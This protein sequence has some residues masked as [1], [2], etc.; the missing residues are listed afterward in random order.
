MK[1]FSFILGVMLFG[2]TS[3]F[4]QSNYRC[5]FSANVPIDSVQVKNMVSGKTKMLYYPDN[6]ITLQ[7]VGQTAIATVGNSAFLQ[8]TANNIVSVNV[9]TTSQLNLTLYSAN[10]T[11]VARYVNAVSAGQYSF[12]IGASAGVYVL[13]ATAGNQSFSIKLFLAKNTPIGIWEIVEAPKISLKSEDDEI[14]F[15]KDDEFEFT[16]YFKE[17]TD[18]KKSKITE[19]TEIVFTFVNDFEGAIKYAFSVSDDKQVYFSQGNLQYQASTGIWR[20]AENQLDYV[21]NE[22]DGTVYENNVKCD[23]ANIS[24]TYDGWIDLFCWA[25]SGWNSGAYRYQPYSVS[26]LQSEYRDF[27]IGN[28]PENDMTGDYAKADWGIYNKIFNG[29]NHVGLWRTLSRDE[30]LY[31]IRGREN[32][33]KKCGIAMINGETGLILLPDEWTLPEG[34]YFRSGTMSSYG[35]EQYKQQNNYSLEDWAKMEANGA[36]FLPSSGK[37]TYELKYK[38]LHYCGYYWLNAHATVGTGSA[39]YAWVVDFSSEGISAGGMKNDDYVARNTRC[40]VRL[41]QDVQ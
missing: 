15:N 14:S 4:S 32:A 35:L 16:G 27:L 29:G 38:M 20:F 34:I 25:T 26:T 24:S 36:V 10:G 11:V 18:Q 37:I 30:W 28:S 8:Q 7:K 12:Q 17:Q 19:D 21:G 22:T 23:N 40:A 6:V 33:G 9:E 41:V 31:L 1:K 13:V 2:A 3:L 5:T 39:A